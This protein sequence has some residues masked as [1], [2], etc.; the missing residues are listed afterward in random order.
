MND[1]VPREAL[2]PRLPREERV[3]KADATC[4]TCG[5]ATQALG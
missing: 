1:G 2:P 4:L 5:S 3:L